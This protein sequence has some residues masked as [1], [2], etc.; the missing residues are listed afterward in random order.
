MQQQPMQPMQQQQQQQFVSQSGTMQPRIDFPEE[1]AKDIRAHSVPDEAYTWTD[2]QVS[3][4]LKEVREAQ[5]APVL[6]ACKGQKKC[7]C[8]LP[9]DAAGFMNTVTRMREYAERVQAQMSFQQQQQTAS[10]L[11]MVESQEHDVESKLSSEQ[12]T[13]EGYQLLSAALAVCLMISVAFNYYNVKG[14]SSGNNN[15]MRSE[16]K[17]AI[18]SMTRA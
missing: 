6:R 9:F 18:A 16:V 10:Q 11:Q 2:Q 15:N 5:C 17:A 4:H 13:A 1:I 12:K 3:Q 14:M 7:K 8:H